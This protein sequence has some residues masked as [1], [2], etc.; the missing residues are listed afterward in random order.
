[1]TDRPQLA[2]AQRIVVKVGSSSLT[3]RRGLDGDRL[4]SLVDSL[5]AL[6]RAGKDVVLVSSGAVAAGFHV[7]TLDLY[8]ARARGVFIT[9]AAVEL[10]IAPEVIKSDLGRVLLACEAKAA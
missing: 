10:K 2:D 8:S 9:Q 6:R 7:D 3:G 1:M 5:A 4:Q